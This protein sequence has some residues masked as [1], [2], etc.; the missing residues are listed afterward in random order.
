[1]FSNL[2][3]LLLTQLSMHETIALSISQ[4]IYH[5]ILIIVITGTF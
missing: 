2:Q 1:M 3:G 4:K 5:N